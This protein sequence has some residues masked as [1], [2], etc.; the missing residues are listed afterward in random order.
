M[1]KISVI[2]PVYGTERYIEKCVRS[3]MEQTFEDIEILCI[4]DCSPDNSAAIIERLAAED[5]RIRLIRH[6]RNLGLGGARNTGI[7]EARAPYLA[8]VDSDDYIDPSMLERL[9][10]ATDGQTVDVVSCG[11]ALVDEDGSVQLNVT[12]P[13]QTFMNDASQV[14][15]LDLLPPSFCNKLWR[16]SL[17]TETGVTFPTHMYY[18]DLATTPRV[19]RF[20]KVIKTI[21]DVLYQYVVRENSITNSYSARHIIDYFR[22]YDTLWDFFSTE[23]LL[24]RYHEEFF[25]KI[26]KSLR[27]H[28]NMIVDSGLDEGE[29]AQYV[30]H[31]LLLKLAYLEYN[32]KLRDLDK[33]SLQLMLLKARSRADID[34]MIGAKVAK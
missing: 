21:Q 26:G 25:V 12:K 28:T 13:N 9:W 16:T 15:I 17:F 4:D 31:M 7:S 18:E 33:E 23:D 32:S 6:D 10:D 19:L 20:A 14:N 8:S 5:K 27:Y 30:R 2:I 1:P 29:K 3:V 11:L 22:T 34:A 24:N